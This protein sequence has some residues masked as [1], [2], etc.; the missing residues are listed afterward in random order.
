MKIQNKNGSEILIGNVVYIVI[1]ILFFA[2]MFGFVIKQSSN[3][4]SYEEINAKKIALVIDSLNQGSEAVI[5]VQDALKVNQGISEP[6]SI[7]GNS[8]VVKLSQRTSY[9]YS[10]FNANKVELNINEGYITIRVK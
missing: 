10:F 5:D 4:H 1:V 8:V 7:N 9:S 6:I 3:V 2:T